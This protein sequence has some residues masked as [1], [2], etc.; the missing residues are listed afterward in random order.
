MEITD[1]IST[2]QFFSLLYLARALTTV[3]Y[4][5][6]YTEGIEASDMFIN[7]LLRIALG[8]IVIIPVYLLYRRCGSKNVIDVIRERSQ[9]AA[10][11]TAV[12]Y[13]SV[14]FYFTVS[15]I[16]RLDVFAGTIIFP[17]TNVNYLLIFIAAICCYGAYLGLQ[18]LG[19]SAVLSLLAV[20]PALVF[21][22]AV[23]AKK[24]I[25]SIFRR[26]CTTE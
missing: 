11:I 3:T 2:F 16:A 10:K 15:T 18:A 12:V 6:S 19:R 17:E 5:P 24:M 23:L 9:L 20:V 21:V 4:I 1:K 25:F 7:V 22:T 8:L 13:A 26:F 14:F